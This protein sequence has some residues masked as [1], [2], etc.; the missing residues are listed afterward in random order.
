MATARAW[1][2]PVRIF[3]PNPETAAVY[4]ERRQ[5]FDDVYTA[6]RPLYPRLR[7]S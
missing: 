2:P 5:L 4:R 3:T 7:I 1:N 6:L